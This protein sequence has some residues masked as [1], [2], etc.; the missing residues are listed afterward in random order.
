MESC[1]NT[2][3]SGIGERPCYL[4]VAFAS[5]STDIRTMAQ[6]VVLLPIRWRFDHGLRNGWI[7]RRATTNE[8]SNP[9]RAP[10]TFVNRKVESLYSFLLTTIAMKSSELACS[11]VRY[12]CQLIGGRT[13]EMT[14]GNHSAREPIGIS[15]R[16]LASSRG[17][18]S[19]SW[20]SFDF[21]HF[22]VGNVERTL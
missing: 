15:N 19:A 6:T 5:T 18:S 16:A 14:S 7:E 10:R 20:E 12:R 3:T 2:G 9:A 8:R 13:E 22:E 21:M 11:T 1:Q 4:V 17:P